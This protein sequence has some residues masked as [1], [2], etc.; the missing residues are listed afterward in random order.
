MSTGRPPD[1]APIFAL[2]MPAYNA[3]S[4]LGEAV[5]SVLAQTFESWELVIVDDGSTDRT[6]SITEAYAAG[7][8]RIR[9]IHQANAGCG[10]A[11][12]VA[13][14][15]SIG[16][17]I[18]HFDADDVLLP[19]CLGAYAGFISDHPSYDIFSCDAEVFGQAGPVVRYY[20]EQRF[21]GEERF[22]AVA[23]FGLEEMFD[24]NLIF[25]AAVVFTRDIYRRAGGIRPDAHTEDYD[26]WLRAMAVGGRHIFVPEVLVR[27]RIGSSQMSASIERILDGSA[28]SLQHLAASGVL[29]LRLTDL[30]R[31]SARRYSRL[32]RRAAVAVRR[33]SCEERLCSG[34]L[35][36][37]RS[38]FLSGR[39]AYGST[40]KFALGLPVVMLSPRLYAAILR[41][42]RRAS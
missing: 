26:L 1:Q 10:P 4:T 31:K 2:A 28:E 13:I 21:P 20:G 7:D 35:G 15:N 36:G 12:S 19:G 5:E 14:D 29:D 17:Y 18:V 16:P 9:V 33:A 22:D 30:A 38:G 25:S 41:R 23:E 32:A 34:D 42:R 11:R 24:S 40:V 39:L 6:P 8:P 27:Y 3:A 37:A